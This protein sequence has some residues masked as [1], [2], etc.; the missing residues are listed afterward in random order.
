[1][2]RFT[3]RSRG[4]FL[5][6]RDLTPGTQIRIKSEVAIE[7]STRFGDQ[8]VGKVSVINPDETETEPQNMKFNSQSI[9][10]LILA[11]GEESK[12]WVG[13]VL[14]VHHEKTMIGGRRETV[15]Y[16]IPDGFE[17]RENENKYLT[18]LPI[19]AS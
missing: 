6:G 18:V 10:G 13:S 14:T 17:V 1:M 4:K 15:T 5:K 19:L 2:A 12:E 8:S 3:K 16:L 11:R 9:E 7:A